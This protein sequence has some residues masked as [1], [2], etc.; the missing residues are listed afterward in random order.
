MVALLDCPRGCRVLCRVGRVPRRRREVLNSE[1][2]TAGVSW[3]RVE[4]AERSRLNFGIGRRA[5]RTRCYLIPIIFFYS[6]YSLRYSVLSS[7]DKG[8]R[9]V[10][11]AS[12]TVFLC[13]Q[14]LDPEV[15]SRTSTSSSQPQAFVIQTKSPE[16]ADY[17]CFA[18]T[19]R[20]ALVELMRSISPATSEVA[21]R[22]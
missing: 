9:N 1:N 22:L 11:S 3:C 14:S 10:S 2:E 18:A 7:S 5:T 12:L 6:R 16:P 20:V 4:V 17:P 8:M 15:Q 19:R 21:K 13:S